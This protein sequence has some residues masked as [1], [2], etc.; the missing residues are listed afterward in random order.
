MSIRLWLLNAWLRLTVKPMLSVTRDP[1]RMR[2]SLE[3]NARR[4]FRA[5][6]DANFVADSIR[7]SGEYAADGDEDRLALMWASCGRP[8]RRR[9]ILY[10]HGGAFIAGSI[11][12]H[13][14]IAARLAGAAGCRAVLPEYSLAPEH[15]F[16]AGLDDAEMT[17]RHLLET[18]YAPGAIA[19]AGDSAGGGMVFA[20]LMRLQ[21]HDLPAPSCVVGFS[22][23]V[24]LT[25]T[26]KSLERNALRDVMLPAKRFTDVARFYLGDLS[27]TND[28]EASPVLG[29]FI[30]PPPALIMASRSEILEDDAVTLAARLREAGGDVQLDLWRRTPHAWPVFAGLLKQADNAVA[31]AGAF[32]N[33][34]LD[35]RAPEEQNG[36]G[37]EISGAISVKQSEQ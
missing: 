37:T 33:R 2:A 1:A 19:L 36:N 10:L 6:D 32:I 21:K 18:G 16:P 12:T 22:P 34:R 8:N 23:W 30:S 26:A 29:D 28:P 17:Y 27:R 3:S 14:H 7:R 4:L 13:R 5:P 9:V 15:P 24:D 20:L 35:E 11:R 25:G 31:R